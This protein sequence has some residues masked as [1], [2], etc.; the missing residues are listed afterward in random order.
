MSEAHH[1]SLCQV[2]GQCRQASSSELTFASPPS[3]HTVF[4]QFFSIRFPHHLGAWIPGTG[5]VNKRFASPHFSGYYIVQQA[6][7][8]RGTRESLLSSPCLPPFASLSR[9]ALNFVL[10]CLYKLFWTQA[11]PEGMGTNG[12]HRSHARC[13]PYPIPQPVKV[14]HTT[15]VY[16]SYSFRT[17]VW[18][19]LRPTRTDQ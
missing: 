12:T 4:A 5:Q 1:S 19:L 15:R 3:P 7:E 13:H 10:F 11:C 9:F 8:E 17:V 14:G 18:V 2:L 6:R 16:V